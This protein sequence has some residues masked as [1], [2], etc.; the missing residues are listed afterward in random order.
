MTERDPGPLAGPVQVGRAAVQANTES[1]ISEQGM[2]TLLS[3]M[4]DCIWD[5]TKL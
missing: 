1:Y 2:Q 3:G 5:R 4:A